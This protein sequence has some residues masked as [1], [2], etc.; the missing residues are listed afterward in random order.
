MVTVMTMMMVM[1]MTMM[2]VMVMVM[3]MLMT[4]PMYPSY[5]RLAVSLPL[6]SSHLQG[7]RQQHH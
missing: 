2:M 1:V 5:L 7:K 3:V 6:S 4:M